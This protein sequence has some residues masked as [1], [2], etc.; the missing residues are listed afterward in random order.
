VSEGSRN[1]RFS[2]EENIATCLPPRCG[3]G[4]SITPSNCSVMK[5]SD[6]LRP[7]RRIRDRR[8]ERVVGEVRRHILY[9]VARCGGR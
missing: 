7:A 4:L 9:P 6:N 2:G 1:P 3:A 5:G 8:C